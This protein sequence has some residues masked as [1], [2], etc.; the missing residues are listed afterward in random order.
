MK[1]LNIFISLILMLSPVFSQTVPLEPLVQIPLN[2]GEFQFFF[3]TAP[4]FGDAPK[5][6]AFIDGKTLFI[7]QV[8][9][10]IIFDINQ[11]KAMASLEFPQTGNPAHYKNG[12][13]FTFSENSFLSNNLEPTLSLYNTKDYVVDSFQIKKDL[14]LLFTESYY[15]HEI[16]LFYSKDQSVVGLTNEGRVITTQEVITK[17]LEWQKNTWYADPIKRNRHKQLIETGEYLIVDGVFYPSIRSQARD[18]FAAMGMPWS[19]TQMMEENVQLSPIAPPIGVSFLGDFGYSTTD[20]MILYNQEGFQL[21]SIDTKDKEQWY[22]VPEERKETVGTMLFAVHPNGDFYALQSMQYDSNYFYR[23]L[24]TWGTDLV[25]MAREGVTSGSLEASKKVVQN[26]SNQELK[27]LRNTFFAL[28]G[29]IFTTWELK[30]YFLGYEWYQPNP[31]V[32]S[33][34]SGF[35]PEQKKL[36]D[37]V[38]AEESRRQAEVAK[39]NSG[40]SN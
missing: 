29:Y 24:K 23:T 15:L 17:Q 28:H 32:T 34:T 19:M 31:T 40:V 6:I 25:K 16:F 30:N 3:S 36:F 10:G 7:A 13:Y 20:A 18:Y 11:K 14:K 33:N 4:Y 5:D 22:K 27:L 1:K 38:V 12:K 26:L 37:L 2:K 39:M 8:R 35:T 9:N 21:A